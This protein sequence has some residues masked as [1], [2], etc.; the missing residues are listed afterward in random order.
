MAAKKTDV[1]K[2]T[3][4]VQDVLQRLEEIEDNHWRTWAV[5]S[6]AA[7][8]GVSGVAPAGG[9]SGGG[10]GFNDGG[11]DG[12]DDGQE[13]GSAADFIKKKR[14]ASDIERIACLAKYLTESGTPQFKTLDLTKLNTSAKQA[15][16]PNA[17]MAMANA[18]QAHLVAAAGGGKKHL[19]SHG[20]DVVNA[21]PGR[22]E[23]T[24]IR[25]EYDSR[26]KRG[27]GRGRRRKTTTKKK[28]KKKARKKKTR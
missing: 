17:S 21:L 12:E 26:A 25:E 15:P 27:R 19:T 28:A 13:H 18:A 10:G 16:I 14:P 5:R 22:A 3:E 4:I 24:K 9:G 8:I 11:S 1:A 2:A 6:I 7:G 20:E 23:V